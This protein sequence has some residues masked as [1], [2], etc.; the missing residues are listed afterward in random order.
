MRSLLVPLAAALA[1]SLAAVHG[2]QWWMVSHS[3]DDLMV[4]YIGDWLQDEA[5]ELYGSLVLLPG[6]AAS[7]ALAHFDPPFLQERS[8]RYFQVLLDG[9]P[10]VRSLSLAGDRLGM[11]AIGPGKHRT[12]LAAG[13]LGQELVLRSVGYELDG[14]RV[15]IG[16]A[17]DLAPLRARFDR[18]MTRYSEITVGAL[19]L[20][21]LLQVAIVRYML[22]ALRRVQTEVARL[23]RGEIPALDEQVPSEVLP[24]VQEINRLIVLLTGRLQRSRQALGD[25]AHGLKTPLAVLKHLTSDPGGQRDPEF[26]RLVDEQV[27]R[28]GNRIDSELKR[29]R[30]AGGRVY[31][32]RVMV[33]T[34]LRALVDAM[35]KLHR[36]KALDI[37][38]ECDGDAAFDGDR[39]DLVELCGN[40]L[41]NACKWANG[42]IS[43][44]V[45]NARGLDIGVEDDGPGCSPAELERLGGRGVRLDETVEGHGLGLAIAQGI[46]ASYGGTISF[47]R[48]AAL[49]GFAVQVA[50]A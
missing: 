40:L 31:G 44:T 43:V 46:V 35:R 48:S 37:R 21:V 38:C 50:F 22:G 45:R 5:D 49:G 33:E 2:V 39:E 16:V 34:E 28:L 20:L 11:G 25:L 32:N 14:K 26:V 12:D 10:V 24:L 30:V 3:V 17:A 27:E 29:A 8:G 36:D 19:V 9:E 7:L 4:G 42:R 23:E 15:T 6:G 18:L 1:V 47:G 41:D 13:P